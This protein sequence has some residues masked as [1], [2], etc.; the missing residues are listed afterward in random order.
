[1]LLRNAE[2]ICGAD[3]LVSVVSILRI[4]HEVLIFA[5]DRQSSRNMLEGTRGIISFDEITKQIGRYFE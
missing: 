2:T 3:G 5:P 1:M 4:D